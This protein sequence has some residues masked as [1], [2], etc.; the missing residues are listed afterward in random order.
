M[1][2]LYDLNKNKID[3]LK[4]YKDYCIESALNGDK[5]LSF[6]YPASLSK[7]IK[8]EGYIQNKHD[9][10]VIKEIQDQDNWKVIKAVLNVEDLEGKEW[11]H[12]DTTEKTIEECLTLAVVGTGWTIGI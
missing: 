5:V 4:K 12:F 10:F 6:L 8:E 9:E 7:N 1:L 3:G 2:Q 11:E